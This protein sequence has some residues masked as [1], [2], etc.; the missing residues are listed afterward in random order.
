MLAADRLQSCLDQRDELEQ[1]AD[2]EPR[3][4][5]EMELGGRLLSHPDGH[6]ETLAARAL[7]GVGG[8]WSLAAFSDP[9][10]PAGEGMKRV[11]D[12]D[13]PITSILL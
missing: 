7:Q 5:F 9:Q 6:V 8:G 11:V 2:V 10:R 13:A 12:P 4:V 3:A 1:L